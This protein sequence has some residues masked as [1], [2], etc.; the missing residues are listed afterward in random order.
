MTTLIWHLF[1]CADI[2]W[3][4]SGLHRLFCFI[5]LCNCI[6]TLEVIILCYDALCI[7]YRPVTVLSFLFVTCVLILFIT[8]Y[9]MC[10]RQHTG[11]YP[12]TIMMSFNDRINNGVPPM[13]RLCSV[14][15]FLILLIQFPPS[16][17]LYIYFWRNC[18]W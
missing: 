3:V 7:V 16:L 10:R 12:P 1:F 17:F 6:Y 18:Y 11:S 15:L 5:L 8:R 2:F 14:L 13:M 9:N 4:H